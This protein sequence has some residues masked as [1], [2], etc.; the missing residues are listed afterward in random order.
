MTADFI[1]RPFET[2]D[3]ESVTSLWERTLPSAQPWNEPSRV[4][5]RK[6][7]AA[8]GL[9]LVGGLGQQVIATVMAGHDGVRGWIYSLAVS[10]QHQLQGLGRRMLEEAERMLLAKG[11]DKVN[12]QVR[13]DNS[14]V[15]EF[16]RRC[17]FAI[18]DRV[19]LGKPLRA[20]AETIVDPVPQIAINDRI[21]LSQ[22]TWDDRP[23]YLKH[24]NESDAFQA[25]TAAMPFPYTEI[26]ADQWLYRAMSE[27]LALDRRRSWAIRDA[28]NLIGGIGIFAITPGEK[29]EIGYWLAQS[30]WGRGI[31]TAA[32]RGL[33]SFAFE[34]YRLHRIYAHV[35]ATNPPSARVMEKAGFELE[36]R[37][38][39]HFCR[40]AQRTDVLCFGKLSDQP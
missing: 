23:E 1:V 26:D 13:A 28:D 17:G 20:G 33:C 15:I 4:I 35:F 24:L 5:H 36:G 29:A 12:L 8:D 37:L 27:T 34:Q 3:L 31:M 18:E 14:D 39:D 40:N 9:F 6:L 16:Y 22:I 25:H 32:V 2:S 38:R 11:C 30:Y 7:A 10:P 21:S 19:S